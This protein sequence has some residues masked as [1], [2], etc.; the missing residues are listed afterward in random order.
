MTKGTET[1][2]EIMSDV[3]I[4]TTDLF[5]V[6]FGMVGEVRETWAVFSDSGGVGFFSGGLLLLLVPSLL[7]Y[8]EGRW[9]H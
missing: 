7:L 2:I 4:T 3:Q 8:I 6:I 1:E 5:R 9:W